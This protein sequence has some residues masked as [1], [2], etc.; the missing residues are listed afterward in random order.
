MDEIKYGPEDTQGRD[1]KG[2]GFIWVMLTSSGK[3]LFCKIAKEDHK[4]ALTGMPF[5]IWH[6]LGLS[7]KGLVYLSASFKTLEPWI[8]KSVEVVALV[9]PAEAESLDKLVKELVSTIVTATQGDLPKMGP[10]GIVT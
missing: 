6:P 3:N 1:F 7:P 10:R 4:A 2:D 5:A 9:H 8:F